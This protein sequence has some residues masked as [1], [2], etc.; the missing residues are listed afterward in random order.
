MLF[1]REPNPTYSKS[2]DFEV[3]RNW[4]AITSSLNI[5]EWYYESTSEWTLDYPPFF[6]WFEWALS[7]IAQFFD[8]NMLRIDNLT[9]SSF[10]TVMFQRLSVIISEFVFYFGV[11]RYETFKQVSLDCRLMRFLLRLLNSMN[12]P[13]KHHDKLLILTFLNPGI[14][15]VDHIHFQYNAFLYGIQLFSIASFFEV[16]YLHVMETHYI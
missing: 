11:C 3:H 14:L 13:K 10:E 2:T 15:F 5:S 8:K 1:T 16:R 12:V 6:A 4:L 9:Y 7:K